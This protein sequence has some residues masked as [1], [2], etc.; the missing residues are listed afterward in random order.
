MS[1]IRHS[2]GFHG[3]DIPSDDIITNCMHCGLCLPTCP[4]YALTGREKSSPRGRIRLIKSVA[5][6]KLEMSNG[7]IDE[8]NFCLD[9]QACETACPAGVKYGSLVESARNQIRL[10]DKQSFGESVLKKFFLRNVLS[11]PRQLKFVARMLWIYQNL[12][13]ESI[14]KKLGI[15]RL[16]TPKLARLQEISPRIDPQFFD[17]QHPE[18]IRPTGTVKHRVGFLSGC[19]MNV[20]FSQINEDTIKVLLHHS[21]EVIIPKQQVCCGSLQA[22][23]GD[24]DVAREL[25]KKNID[26]FSEYELDAIIMNSAGCGA[27]MKEYGHYLQDDAEYL[28]KAKLIASKVKDISEFL[29]DIGLKPATDAFRHKVTYHDA[30]HLVHSQ[31]ISAQPRSLLKS[32]SGLE[33]VELNEAS[34]CCGSAGIY[35]VVRYEDS[36]KILERK[37]ENIEIANAE[38]I[39][40]NNPGCLLQ[41]EHGCRQHSVQSKVVHLSTLL[42]EV[43]QI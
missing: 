36:M 30:C 43:Y 34:W 7:F 24:F 29:F 1:E 6:G 41:I 28:T 39:V 14:L 17:E 32:I 10:Q 42:K 9:C 11:N 38:Y 15:A 4:T 5:E 8:M 23:N 35:N 21:C 18:V 12:G 22:H 13:V 2:N 37:M 3:I 19:V 25:A 16:L 33:Y 26:I 20:A 40:A 31:K 27:M